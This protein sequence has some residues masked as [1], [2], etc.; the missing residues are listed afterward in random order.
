MALNLERNQFKKSWVHLK[1]SLTKTN[2]PSSSFMWTLIKIQQTPKYNTFGPN[3]FS[4]A[5]QILKWKTHP[6]LIN[7]QQEEAPL[8]FPETLKKFNLWWRNMKI[9]LE[10]GFS[11]DEG[12][13]KMPRVRPKSDEDEFWKMGI[14]YLLRTLINKSDA[15]LRVSNKLWK[16][17]LF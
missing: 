16:M 8:R 14:H 15:Y 17:G 13:R 6:W 1:I 11:E 2:F 7:P 4:T 3:I 5:K 9:C 12:F 10:Y